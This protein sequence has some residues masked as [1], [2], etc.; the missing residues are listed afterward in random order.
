MNTA[1]TLAVVLYLA[2]L[3]LVI[4]WLRKRVI[5]QT[6]YFLAGRRMGTVLSATML[7]AINFGG[8]FVIGTSQDAYSVGFAAIAFA[9]GICVG[10]LVLALFV[11]KRIRQGDFVTVPDF[12][13]KAYSSK[14]VRLLAAILSIAGLTGILAGQ[15][16]AAASSLTILGLN[17][18]LAAVVGVVLIIALTVIAGMWGVA[19]TDFIQFCVIV[20]GLLTVLFIAL[21]TAGGIS[22]I[23]EQYKANGLS[24]PFNPLNQGWSFLLG[25]ALPVVVHKLVGQ[26]VMQRVF[27]A[28]S[29][30]VAAR[31]AAI[32]GIV[33]AIFS[34]VPALAGMAAAVIIPDL[35]PSV[36]V[37]PAL[38][39][40]VLPVWAAGI[41]IAAIISAVLSTANALLL[42]AVSNISG[43]LLPE[44][45]WWSRK[46]AQQQ[47]LISRSITVALG[48]L[49]FLLSLL[50]PNVITILTMAFT[51]Y[52]SAVFV[53]FMF[54]MF[55]N[56]GNAR[57]SLV[58]MIGGGVV[59]LLGLLEVFVVPGVP[60]IVVAIGISFVLFIATSLIPNSRTTTRVHF[61]EMVKHETSV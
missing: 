22:A 51:M 13:G 7:L 9:L 8:A 44:L 32:A 53:S 41:L 19:V 42:A 2:A 1:L 49:A 27:A 47:L 60:V 15:V 18:Q 14:P 55:S 46:S 17:Y 52:G 24:S 39:D 11:A 58:S 59:A 57:A 16:G 30:A 12:L 26:D 36:G 48:A 23:S 31:A 33:T 37:V 56:F 3:F 54:A 10:F 61:N 4:L 5:S 25:A 38:I 40:E 29:G 28:K 34:V 6:D 21:D 45:N 20:G 35:D 43:D 50:V